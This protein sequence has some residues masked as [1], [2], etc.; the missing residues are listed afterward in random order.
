[1]LNIKA[2]MSNELENNRRREYDEFVVAT[3]VGVGNDTVLFVN[4]VVVVPLDAAVDVDI[5]VALVIILEP[6]VS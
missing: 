3:A 4:A 1:V 5:A 2:M 6:E